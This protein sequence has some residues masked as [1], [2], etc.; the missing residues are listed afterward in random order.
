MHIRT[1]PNNGCITEGEVTYS[2]ACIFIS[3]R[4]YFHSIGKKGKTVKRLRRRAKFTDSNHQMLDY[5]F[6]PRHQEQLYKLLRYY[7]LSLALI[8]SETHRVSIV[9]LVE[10]TTLIPILHIVDVHFEFITNIP[11]LHIGKARNST[12]TRLYFE[13]IEKKRKKFM[14][15]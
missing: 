8:N 15:S 13:L 6:N 11:V 1:E 3:I 10:D 7:K 9:G 5:S 14:M 12:I 2:N 4:D